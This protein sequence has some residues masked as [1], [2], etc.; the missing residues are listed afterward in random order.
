VKKSRFSEEKIIAP[1][2]AGASVCGGRPRRWRKIESSH[3][4]AQAEHYLIFDVVVA[5]QNNDI[6]G[7]RE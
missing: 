4:H 7:M 1:E 2:I 3:Q 6:T 5:W